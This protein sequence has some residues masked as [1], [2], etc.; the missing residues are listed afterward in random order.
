MSNGNL[1]VA[2]SESIL[3]YDGKSFEL[4]KKIEEYKSYVHAVCA[5]NDN[6]FITASYE[7][8]RLIFWKINTDNYIK[9]YY[10]NKIKICTNKILIFDEE[11]NNV[12]VGARNNILI[13]NGNNYQIIKN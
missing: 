8:S 13:I 9:D 6:K 4:I 2:F 7:D 5:I 3:I 1:V 12:I 11:K 10:L